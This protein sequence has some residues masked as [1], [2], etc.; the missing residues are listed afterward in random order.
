MFNVRLV[1][2]ASIWMWVIANF[3]LLIVVKMLLSSVSLFGELRYLQGIAA[4]RE[5]AS[6]SIRVIV[7][8]AILLLAM[9]IQSSSCDFAV[10]ARSRYN[11]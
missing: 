7:S 6:T 2:V 9:F 1:V 8:V 10:V 3:C 4:C 5:V 11:V